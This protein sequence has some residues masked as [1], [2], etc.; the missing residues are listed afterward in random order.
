MSEAYVRGNKAYDEDEAAKQ[1][2][3]ELN[4]RIYDIQTAND[5]DSS[6]AQ[7]YWT[8]RQW[9]YDALDQFYLRIKVKFDKYYPESQTAPIGLEIVKRELGNGVFEESDGAVVFR[10]EK[11][12]LHTR[13]F[14]NNQGLPTYETKDVGLAILKDRDYHFDKSLIITGNEQEQYMAVVYKAIEQFA[15]ELVEKTTHLTHGMVRLAG[16]VKMSSRAGNIIKA[17]DILDAAA[18]A[19]KEVSGKDDERVVLAAVKYSFLKQRIGGDIIFDPKD[20]VSI[21]GNSGPYLQYAHARAR[22][23]LKKA[24]A[25]SAENISDLMDSE[26]PLALKLSRYSQVVALA[27]AELSPHQVCTY[28]YDLAQVFNRFYEQNRVIGDER[29]ETRLRLVETYAGRLKDG[30]ELLG[31]EAPERL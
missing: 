9:S 10:A 28:L 6:L 26:R 24:S 31:I 30:L 12:G 11:Y 23:I 22:S 25:A 15:P 18:E 20:S 16:N 21:L 5:H 4:K 2:I 14:I 19:S 3:K 27:A 17:T 13:V 1:Q 8:T 7:I 29:E